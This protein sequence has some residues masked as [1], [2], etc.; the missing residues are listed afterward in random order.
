MSLDLR[1]YSTT[2]VAELLGTSIGRVGQMIRSGELVAF[3]ARLTPGSRR[4][5][6]RIR[7]ADLEDFLRRR[8]VRPT[9]EVVTA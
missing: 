6:F 5:R 7:P 1:S 2:E 8:K 9:R 3:D 4:P